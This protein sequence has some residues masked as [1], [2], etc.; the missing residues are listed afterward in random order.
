MSDLVEHARRELELCGQTAEDP[1]Y[2]ASIIAAVAA[3]TSYGGHSGGSA[4]VAV[5]QLY[6]LLRYRTLSPLTSSPEEWLDQSYVSSYP[7]WQ[8][9]RDPAAI[10][11]NGGKTWSFVDERSEKAKD[12]SQPS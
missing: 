11:Y 12:P 7:V 2:A 1:L 6:D 10:S 9:L 5:E 4:M 3:F 8:N